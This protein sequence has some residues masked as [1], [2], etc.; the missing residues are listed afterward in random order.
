MK[1]ICSRF[2]SIAASHRGHVSMNN[3]LIDK[4]N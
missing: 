4:K 3:F 2:K 1:S